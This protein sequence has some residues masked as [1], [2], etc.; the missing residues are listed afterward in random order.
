[1]EVPYIY[2]GTF[3]FFPDLQK[4]ITNL[5]V[6]TQNSH[7]TA[8]TYYTFQALLIQLLNNLL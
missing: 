2:S 3:E 7:S 6:H 4:N 5:E 8:F 1:M